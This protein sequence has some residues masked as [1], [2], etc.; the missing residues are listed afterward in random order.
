M[1][2]GKTTR[3]TTEEFIKRAKE[4]Y[5][6][7]YDYSKVNY[8]N[9]STKVTIICPI[10][11]EFEKY[12]LDFLKGQEC[13][14]CSNITRSK[15]RKLTVEQFIEKARK[16]HGD[17]YDY[18]KVNYI[19]NHTKVCIICSVHGEFWQTPDRHLSGQGCPRCF[20]HVYDVKSFITE[21]QKIHGDT[22]DYSKVNYVKSKTKV[23][24]V[25]PVH[26]EFWQTPYNH[27]NG[28]GCPKCG[29]DR[30]RKKQLLTT[31]EFIEKARKV[32]GD[33]YDY[34]KTEYKNSHTKVCIICSVHGEFW[35]T[36]S[37]H[38][39]GCGCPICKES[40]LEKSLS[41]FLIEKKINF[42]YRKNFDWLGKQ[43]LD[44]YLPDYNI[45]IECQGKQHFIGWDNKEEYLR[46]QIL[47][48]EKKY[49]LS[50]KHGVKIL[51]YARKNEFKKVSEIYS[52]NVFTRKS[53]L[54]KITDK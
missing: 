9:K 21:A 47:S 38:L 42:E 10:H 11:G 32:H 4:I 28:Q 51:Y 15:K 26:G 50:F 44:F 48:D 7:K 6:D 27:L 25:C 29:I 37:D 14:K 46:K 23:C 36:P 31:C 54:F 13:Q 5:K 24:I 12:P 19:N 53:D 16:V 34:S 39:G 41:N 45:A 2:M 18:S 35:Q 33:K 52:K 43:H 49:E 20:K 3:L 40:K 1:S 30:A 22:Y 8:I 17:K